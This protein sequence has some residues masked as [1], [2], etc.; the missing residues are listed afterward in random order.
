VNR[1]VASMDRRSNG[2]AEVNNT[3]VR[4]EC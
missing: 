3:E 1:N 4:L 2:D